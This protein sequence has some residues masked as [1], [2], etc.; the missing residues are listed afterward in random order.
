MSPF[1]LSAAKRPKDVLWASALQRDSGSEREELS[2]THPAPL[3]SIDEQPTGN[4]VSREF[5]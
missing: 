3:E 1:R 5:D 2:R 4:E